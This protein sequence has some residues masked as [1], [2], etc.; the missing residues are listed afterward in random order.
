MKEDLDV[1][2]RLDPSGK[3]T[4]HVFRNIIAPDHQQ[5]FGRAIGKE[6]RGLAGRIAATSH[7]NGLLTTNL[8][9]QRGRS[10]VKAHTFK[11]FAT[12]R[13]QSPVIRARGDQDT[14]RSQDGG[15]TFDLE[16]G[17]VFVGAVA[18]MKREC[19]RRRGKFRTESICLKLSQPGQITAANPGWE[20]KKVLDQRGGTSLAARGITFQHNCAQSFGG[21]I[22]G[23]GKAGRTCA[24]DR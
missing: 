8:A 22:N 15:A 12:F 10:V 2:L 13:I 17:A 5:H 16:T 9:F 3:I 7:D 21:G 6:H 24:D 20:T 18:V 23:C 14:F 4:R 11:L 1:V 19:L